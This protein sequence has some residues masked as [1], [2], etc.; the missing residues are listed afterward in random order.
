MQNLAKLKILLVDD[1]RFIRRSMQF[2]FKNKVRRIAVV[3]DAETAF[4]LLDGA[5]FNVIICDYRLPGVNGID[6]FKALG[7]LEPA[8]IKIL[9]T[10]YA[11]NELVRRAACAGI[12]ELIAKPFSSADIV[13]ELLR[14]TQNLP[15]PVKNKWDLN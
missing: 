14:L 12:D 8:P 4:G 3:Q 13:Q 5:H 1:D 6:F 15:Q 2:A 9:I 11:D 10:A 7:C